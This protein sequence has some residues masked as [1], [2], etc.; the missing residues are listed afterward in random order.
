MSNTLTIPDANPFDNY[1]P[2]VFS[3]KS[4][5]GL[6]AKFID[7]EYFVGKDK[8]PWATDRQYVPVMN[9]LTRGWQKFWRRELVDQRSGLY[10]KGFRAPKRYELGD[11]DEA[12][13]EL[14]VD[15]KP[16]D[17]WQ[18]FA[19]VPFVSTDLKDTYTFISSSRGGRTAL[20]NLA[21]DHRATPPGKY[22]LV[23]LSTDFYI[24]PEFQRKI[25]E[26]VFLA[27]DSY[28]EA[29]AYDSVIAKALSERAPPIETPEALP[30]R[31]PAES[32]SYMR[33]AAPIDDSDANLARAIDDD[34]RF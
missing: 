20:D 23:T 29:G 19:A 10:V 5:P 26:P 15:G 2:D 11:L 27:S 8:L 17:P 6:L 7:R 18:Q 14:G 28:V 32:I 12:S 22:P 30:E 24:H 4:F 3:R 21:K 16:R 34:I 1:E 31:H 9:Y 13:W 33:P 25:W